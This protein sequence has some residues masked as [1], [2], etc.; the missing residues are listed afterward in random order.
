LRPRSGQ[1]G[2]RLSRSQITIQ[3]A[4]SLTEDDGNA[5]PEIRQLSAWA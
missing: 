1:S 5:Q 2:F 4:G 3:A